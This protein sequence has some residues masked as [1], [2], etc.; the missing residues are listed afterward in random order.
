MTRFNEI[1]SSREQLRDILGEPPEPVVRKT[2]S[3]LD[4]H[5]GV[6]INRSPFMLLATSDAEGQMDVSPKGDPPGFVKILDEHTL[7]I[8]DRPGNRRADSLENILQNPKVGLIFL[9]PGKRE[10]L[11]VSGTAQIVTDQDLRDSMAVKGRSPA[12]AIVVTVTEA[13]FHCSKCMIRSKMWESEHWPSLE[14]LPRLAQT[15]VDAGK[16]ELSE[17]DL[18]ARVVEDERERLY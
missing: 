8:P 12:I 18:H 11:R 5:C 17:E 14:G 13:F 15:M 3:Q 1:I 16:L 4:R 6:F 2:L 10:T 9:V 7:V